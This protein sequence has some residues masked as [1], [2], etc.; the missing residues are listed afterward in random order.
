VPPLWRAVMHPRL[1]EYRSKRN[2]LYRHGPSP[3]LK[4]D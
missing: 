2:Q 3:G 4:S 1:L